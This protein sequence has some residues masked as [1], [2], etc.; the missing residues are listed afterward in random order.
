M[1]IVQPYWSFCSQRQEERNEKMKKQGADS[2]N[3]LPPHIADD[4]SCFVSK[5]FL[6]RYCE[7][8]V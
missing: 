6:I 8:E 7:E 2:H 5:T 3:L 1:E 4:Q